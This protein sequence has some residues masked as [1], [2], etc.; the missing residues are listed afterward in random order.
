MLN[1]VSEHGRL[2]RDPELR[3]TQ[4]GVAVASFSIAVDQDFTGKDGKR[5][6]DFFDCTAWR[7]T[8][9]H[10]AKYFVKGQ[11]ILIIGSLRNESWTDKEGKERKR[12]I[13]LVDRADFCGSK[14]KTD[15]SMAAVVSGHYGDQKD[16]RGFAGDF[17]L[18]DGEDELP[19]DMEG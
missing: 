7:Q 13:I 17:A 18:L 12:N 14:G 2:T 1:H 6:V 10:I 15:S 8:A 3:R 19:F 4:S 11:E 9:E 5:V 16:G